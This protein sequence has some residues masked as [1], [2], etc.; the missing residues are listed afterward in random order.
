MVVYR[1]EKFTRRYV[2]LLGITV[3]YRDFDPV[4][5]GTQTNKYATDSV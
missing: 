5:C 4:T 1:V 2:A 3:Y